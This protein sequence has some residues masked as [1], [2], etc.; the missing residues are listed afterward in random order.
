MKLN[1]SFKHFK[2][3]LIASSIL[4]FSSCMMVNPGHFSGMNNTSNTSK[5]S[6]AAMDPV[7]GKSIENVQ[8]TLSYQHL[9]NTYYF[10]SNTCL[11]KFQHSPDAFLKNNDIQHG[12]RNQN[13]FLWGM[14]AVA[15][16]GMMVIIML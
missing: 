7:C 1:N 4:L 10:D 6:T 9:N 3:V 2:T 13:G 15:M 5:Q 14:G 16:L 11:D 12:A 8:N